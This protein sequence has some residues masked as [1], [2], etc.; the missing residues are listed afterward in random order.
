MSKRDK[1]RRRNR[2]ARRE[3]RAERQ[4]CRAEG[5]LP[6]HLRST[7]PE[8]RDP[9]TRWIHLR[10]RGQV[11]SFIPTGLSVQVDEM[12]ETAP[13]LLAAALARGPTE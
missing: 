6:D 10:A 13:A 11:I 4:R 5:R 7:K 2:K 3:V 9:R 8:T 12:D 1:R